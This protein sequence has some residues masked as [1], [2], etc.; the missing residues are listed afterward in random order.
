[1]PKQPPKTL[2]RFQ[3][4]FPSVWKSYAGLRDSCDHAGS[5]D[6]KTVELIKVAIEVATHRHGGLIAHVHRAQAV[7]A[8]PEDIFHALLLALPLVG[9]PETLEAFRVAT[10]ALER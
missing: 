1:M 6:C 3:R 10:E 5:L 4:E 2:Q 9:F 8:T 7:G